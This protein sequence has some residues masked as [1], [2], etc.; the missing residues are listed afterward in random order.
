MRNKKPKAGQARRNNPSEQMDGIGKE[1]PRDDPVF[2]VLNPCGLKKE[3]APAALS[4]RIPD[5][6]DKVIYCVSQHI[7]GAD[8][9]LKK[10]AEALPGA[11]P[12]VKA[13]YERRTTA[14]MTDNPEL[15]NALAKN[16]DAVIY[17]CGA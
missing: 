11:V 13:V 12:G 8:V 5:F 9:F 10:V 2:A 4:P 3:A 17:G 16:A 7:G 15:W 6:T 1:A 14:Y